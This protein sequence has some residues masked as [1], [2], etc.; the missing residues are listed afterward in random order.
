VKFFLLVCIFFSI[1]GCSNQ[2]AEKVDEEVKNENIQKSI[3]F[4]LI[5]LEDHKQPSVG[6]PRI[7]AINGKIEYIAQQTGIDDHKIAAMLITVKKQLE[8]KKLSTN[9]W[10]VI[11]VAQQSISDKAYPMKDGHTVDG[12]ATYLSQYVV[13]R[14]VQNHTDSL[15]GLEEIHKMLKDP[16]KIKQLENIVNN[17]K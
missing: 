11:D 3:G 2:V 5:A 12:L 15:L 10:E 16:E 9:I 13:S 6:D 7:N 17:S 8:E 4:D 14:T 1:L